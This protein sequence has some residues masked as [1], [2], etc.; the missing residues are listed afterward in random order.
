MAPSPWLPWT[1][2]FLCLGLW[3]LSPGTPTGGQTVDA[4]LVLDPNNEVSMM[5]LGPTDI[6]FLP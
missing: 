1:Q 4:G 2:M 3:D 6:C 5:Q